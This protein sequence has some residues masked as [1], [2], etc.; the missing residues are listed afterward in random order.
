MSVSSKELISKQ[1]HILFDG[2]MRDIIRTIRPK[3]TDIKIPV[4]IFDLCHLFYQTR[5]T[6]KD[7]VKL[8]NFSSGAIQ[9]IGKLNVD[10]NKNYVG[11][12]FVEKHYNEWYDKANNNH[13]MIEWYPNGHNGV[14][15]KCT[16]SHKGI[17]IPFD[18]IIDVV[19]KKSQWRGCQISLNGITRQI[20]QGLKRYY[21]HKNTRYEN[22][23]GQTKFMLWVDENGYDSGAIK[24]EFQQS[25]D[26]AAIV[27]FDEDFPTDKTDEEREIEIFKILNACYKY[28]SAF[29]NSSDL[30]DEDTQF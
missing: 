13:N 16:A 26:E 29:F 22:E 3:N 23:Y 1:R 9:W 15:F 21:G 19:G 8:Y 27:D 24:E 4:E 17:F 12:V 2:F 6:I 5:F 28:P 10:E 18:Y 11:I 20:D 25:P 14:T 7:I 30:S